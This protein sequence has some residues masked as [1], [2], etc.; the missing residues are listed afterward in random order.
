MIDPLTDDLIPLRDVPSILKTPKKLNPVTVWRWRLR[1][2]KGVRLETVLI[3]QNYYTTAAALR[4]FL[5]ASSGN[6]PPAAPT[7]KARAARAEK[8]L[9]ELGV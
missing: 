1:G 6:T 7:R 5:A 3:G 8:E 2:R 9:T 4:A